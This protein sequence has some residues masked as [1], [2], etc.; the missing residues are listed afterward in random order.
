ML[1]SSRNGITP[2]RTS[3]DHTQLLMSDK[4]LRAERVTYQVAPGQLETATLMVDGPNKGKYKDEK[5]GAYYIDNIAW[6]RAKNT[7]I[8]IGSGAG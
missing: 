8:P 4:P 3:T 1:S 5:T 2:T 7:R 6:I